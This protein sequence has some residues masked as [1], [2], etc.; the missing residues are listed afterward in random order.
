LVI[1][2]DQKQVDIMNDHK[3]GEDGVPDITLFANFVRKWRYPNHDEPLT[4][5]I[6]EEILRQT[7]RLLEAKFGAVRV[8]IEW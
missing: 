7:V 8:R 3:I 1:F 6:K 5:E 4:Q 2:E